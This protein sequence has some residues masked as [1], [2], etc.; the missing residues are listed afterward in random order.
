ML[1]YELWMLF[2]W[3]RRFDWNSVRIV[4][5]IVTTTSMIVKSTM[6]TFW[7]RLPGLSE[8]CQR[9]QCRLCRCHI[10]SRKIATYGDLPNYFHIHSLLFTR[11]T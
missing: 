9:N 10:N 3:R 11:A 4:T 5:P 8:K 7:Y 1:S 6:E 2:C